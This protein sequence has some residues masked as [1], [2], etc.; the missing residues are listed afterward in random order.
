[1]GVKEEGRQGRKRG[2]ECRTIP[3][4]KTPKDLGD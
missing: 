2:K 1:M 4:T 3:E